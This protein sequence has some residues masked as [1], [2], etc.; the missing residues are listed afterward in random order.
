MNPTSKEKGHSV[1]IYDQQRVI[2]SERNDYDKEQL[3]SLAEKLESH[4]HEPFSIR[5]FARQVTEPTAIEDFDKRHAEQSENEKRLNKERTTRLKRTKS[6]DQKQATQ[7][8]R[9]KSFDQKQA[10]YCFQSKPVEVFTTMEKDKYKDFKYKTI[11]FHI[12][13]NPTER[14]NFFN[15]NE[16]HLLHVMCPN[17]SAA[18]AY[19]HHIGNYYTLSNSTTSNQSRLETSVEDDNTVSVQDDK[20]GEPPTS[21]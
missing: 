13:K 21:R 6:V 18:T 10:T 9:T 5:V 15:K 4:H 17:A 19:L 8:T 7:S 14:T 1:T 12:N 11:Q 20:P 2:L 3:A 16:E